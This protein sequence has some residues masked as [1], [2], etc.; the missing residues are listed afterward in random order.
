MRIERIIAGRAD[1]VIANNAT[2]L[3]D[4]VRLGLSR[5]RISVIPYGVDAR[6]MNP[7]GPSSEHSMRYRIV[8]LDELALNHGVDDVVKAMPGVPDTELIVAGGPPAAQLGEDEDTQRIRA[9]ARRIGVEDRVTLL[10]GIPPDRVP[11]L[12]RGSDAA[13]AVPWAHATGKVALDAMGCGV[14]V[15]CTAM[16]GL[17]DAVV[18]GP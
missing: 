14:P 7:D 12:L 2:E 3:T 8:T 13:V 17:A 16:G 18:D 4:L 9:L 5:M 6:K 15:V 10:G 1:A 11:A